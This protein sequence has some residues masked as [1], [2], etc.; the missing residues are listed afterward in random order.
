MV[1]GILNIKEL[2][3]IHAQMVELKKREA[4]LT[5]PLL[6]DK[7]CIPPI[8]EWFCELSGCNVSV[9]DLDTDNK[10]EFLLIILLFYSPSFFTGHRLKNGLRDI[11]TELFGYK[12]RS[13]VSNHLKDIVHTYNTYR[14]FREEVTVLYAEIEKR[15]KN[16]GL[17][18]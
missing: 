9:H 1:N 8:F 7:N 11:L 15:L 10:M 18:P 16:R 14:K 12:S 4:E 5:T 2:L 6:T 3:S 13:G 17:I